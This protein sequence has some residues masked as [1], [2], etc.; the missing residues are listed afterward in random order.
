MSGNP[1]WRTRFRAD[2]RTEGTVRFWLGWGRVPGALREAAYEIGR[3][4]PAARRRLRRVKLVQV[5][6]GV[7][8]TGAV[9]ARFVPGWVPGAG[10]LPAVPF[11][12]AVCLRPLPLVLA[13][14]EALTPAILAH[15]MAHFLWPC[16]PRELRRELPL[17]LGRLEGLHPELTV[18]LDAALS[19]YRDRRSPDEC[20]VRLLEWW[21][22]G[23][24]PF[25]AEL[26]PFYAGWIEG[27]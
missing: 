4:T 19:E 14:R 23:R 1:H 6:T 21:D 20:H 5:P 13:V 10:A 15:E 11:V 8:W 27:A 3:F 25:P 17:V 7:A 12:G 18:W 26:R 22:Y 2:L 9:L 16:L 24:R